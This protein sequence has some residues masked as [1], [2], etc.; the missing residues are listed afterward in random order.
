MKQT[1]EFARSGIKPGDIRAFKPIAVEAGHR[2]IIEYR[3]AAMLPGD[4]MIDLEGEPI[5]WIRNP[6]VLAAVGRS[7]PYLLNQNL[8]H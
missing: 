8:V 1:N 5:V 6:A 2:K 3:G 7:L 4:N